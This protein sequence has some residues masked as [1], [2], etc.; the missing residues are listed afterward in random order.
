[1]VERFT[2]FD[3]VRAQFEPD[4]RNSVGSWRSEMVAA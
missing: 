4:Q 2:R 1:M 3:G